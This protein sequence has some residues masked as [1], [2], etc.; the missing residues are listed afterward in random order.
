MNKPSIQFPR[1]LIGE[2]AA[3]NLTPIAANNL[4]PPYMDSHFILFQS[5]G[6]EVAEETKYYNGHRHR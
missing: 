5:I 6:F 2:I 4:T 3:N 1:L